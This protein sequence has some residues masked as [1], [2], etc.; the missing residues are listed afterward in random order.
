M[1]NIIYDHQTFIGQEFGGISRYFCELAARVHRTEGFSARVIAPV[2]YNAY[3][4]DCPVP[5]SALR[6]PVRFRGESRLYRL[7]NEALSPALTATAAPSLVHQT[8]Y[9]PLAS[10]KSR[11]PIVLTVFDMIHELFPDNFP[12]TDPIFRCKAACV[13]AADHVL[14]ISQSTANDLMRLFGVPAEKISITYL[15]YSD[16]FAQTAEATEL[17]PHV[18]PYVLYVGHRGGYKNF[19]TALRAYASSARLRHEFDFVTFGGPASFSVTEQATMT[20]LS[21]RLGSVVR[22]GGSD[23][24][25][26]RAYRHARAF[27]YPSRYEGFGIPP[28][29][30]MASGCVTVCADSSSIPEVVGDAGLLFNP[31]DVDAARQSLEDACFDEALRA[32]LLARGSARV[33][34]FSWDRCAHETVN[35]YRQMIGTE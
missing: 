5:Q 29:E 12:A 17:P 18:R 31:D 24:H 14:C 27:I 7:I 32:Q 15:A 26:A 9:S 2:H 1:H 22:L 11:T 28:L 16:I 33:R 8:Y 19:E 35:A 21:L 25:L 4:P 6:M 23:E 3:L 34:E 30:A 13:A 20:N 10:R